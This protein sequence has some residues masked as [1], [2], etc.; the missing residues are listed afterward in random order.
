MVLTTLLVLRNPCFLEVGDG[1]PYH[2]IESALNDVAPGGEIDVYPATAEYPQT[3]LFISKRILLKARGKICLDGA[4]FDYSGAGAIPRAI[5]QVQPAGSGTAI[6]GF[7]LRGA[8]NASFNGA[9]IRINGANQVTVSHCDIHGNDM[10]IM[11]NGLTGTKNW[12]EDQ[13]FRRCQIHENGTQRDP[14]LNHN[15]YL[16]GRSVFIDECLIWGALTG[17]N[18]KSRAHYTHVAN[19]VLYGGANRQID[20]VDSEYTAQPNSNLVIE[21]C[22]LAMDANSTGNGNVIHFGA[23]KGDRNGTA[24]LL[25]STVYTE[26]LPPILLLDSADASAQ[27]DNSIIIDPDPIHPTL[28]GTAKSARAPQRLGSGNWVS[29]GYTVEDGSTSSRGF[30]FG[31]VRSADRAVPPM[32]SS[33]FQLIPP[34]PTPSTYSYLDGEGH[35]R[36]EPIKPWKIGANPNLYAHLIQLTK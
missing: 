34:M 4:G 36:A 35:K 19:S 32:N 5:I 8:R 11:S 18:L 7:E 20:C 10:G 31:K 6:E 28:L 15:L 22:I 27:V 1:K 26:F 3:A 2:R 9:G 29:D 24:Y 14:G 30:L 17:H 12:A 16:G 21:N 23:E 33:G 25:Q 13:R